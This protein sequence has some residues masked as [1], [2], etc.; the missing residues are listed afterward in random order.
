MIGMIAAVL[1][2]FGFVPQVIKVI[3]TK[4]TESIA[5]GMYLMT[6]IG[7]GLWLIH[8]L[9]IGD[10]ALITANSIS[11]VLAGIVLVYKIKYK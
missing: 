3:R 4:D 7:M 2:T 9:M 5:L 1:T 10:L 11:F 8:G 6:V